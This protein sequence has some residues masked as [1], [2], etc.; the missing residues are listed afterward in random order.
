MN[1]LSLILVIPL[2]AAL[3]S[4]LYKSSLVT[5]RVISITALSCSTAVSVI[6]LLQNGDDGIITLN[7]GSWDSKIGIVLVADIFSSFMLVVTGITALCVLIYSVKEIETRIQSRFFYPLFNLLILGVNGSFI[8]GD[9]FNLYVWFEV[10]LLSSFVLLTIGRKADQLEG[11]IKYVIINLF[12]SFLFLIG[13]G[14]LYA[15][16]GSLNLADL[17]LKISLDSSGEMVNT[18][19][20][21]FLVSFGF[22]AALFPFFFWLPASY[23]TPPTSIS[24]LFAGLLTKVGVY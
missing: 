23:H 12:S 7:T 2:A 22:K 11:A 8:T 9:I 5:Q 15:K 21:I 19:G 4:A 16:V 3:F 13:V 1:L 6:L 14:L 20:V 10:M 18:T 24:A 17:A